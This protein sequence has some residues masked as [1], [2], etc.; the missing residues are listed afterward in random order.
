MEL[1]WEDK[2]GEKHVQVPI[3]LPQIPHRLI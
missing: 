3:H 2:N 1:W